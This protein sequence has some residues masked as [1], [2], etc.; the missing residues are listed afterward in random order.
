MAGFLNRL[1]A[2]FR[3]E[4]RAITGQPT[5]G[6]SWDA[7][8]YGGPGSIGTEGMLA[9]NLAAVL[10][11]VNVVSSGLASLPARVYQQQ[12][13]GRVEAPN[14]PVSRL[15]AAPN[16][17]QTW[18]DLIEWI[19]GSVLLRGNA[20][21]VIGWDGRGAPQTLTPVPWSRVSVTLL[22]S[23][24]L[25]YAISPPNGGPQQILSQDQVFHLKDR[26][27]DGYVGR[28]RLD[29]AREALD[30]AKAAQD[31]AS[32][33]WRNAATPSGV[34]EVPAGVSAEGFQRMRSAFNARYAGQENAGSV[35]FAD[36]GAKF[37]ATQISPEDAQLLDTRR[38]TVA[39]IARIFQVPPPLLQDYSNSTFTNAAQAS[40]WFAQV[41]LTP[42]ARKIEAEFAR[43]VFTDGSSHLE[44]DLTGLLRGDY[45]TRWTANVAAV[46]AGILTKDE[47]REQE[48][49]GP[50]PKSETEIPAAPAPVGTVTE[51][52]PPAA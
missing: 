43:S 34:L 42:W 31:F 11:A 1:A 13:A 51:P 18:P 17:Q 2:V 47:I 9:E 4:K 35:I 37:T 26:S 48:G 38:F 41:T 15:I 44:V 27:D 23:L 46:G 28:S 21:C 16:D 29:R 39:E 6:I 19:M 50:L 25:Q 7:M 40:I 5:D 49:Y 3:P 36:P 52:P 20:L 8:R 12:D 30:G 33:V 14:H 22:P 32:A 45:A 10:A 24:R